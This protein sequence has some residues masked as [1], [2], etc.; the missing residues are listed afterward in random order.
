MFM[1]SL[2]IAG[3]MSASIAAPAAAAPPP[4]VSWTVGPVIAGRSYSH[5]VPP[6]AIAGPGRSWWVPIPGRS[7]SLN[8]LTMT[9]RPLSGA[10]RIVLTYRIE[11]GPGVTVSARSVPGAPA[12]V[13]LYLQRRGDDWSARGPYEAY[14]WYASFA[15]QTITPNVTRTIVAPLT[16]NWTAVERSS[17]RTSPA[18]FRAALADPQV[19]G[20]VLGGGDGLGHGIVADGPARLVVTDFRIE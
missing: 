5:E 6:R 7:G 10:R 18:A 4:P 17:A 1:R 20:F 19:V 9:A 13:T 14:R 8:A 2:A 12:L 11:A 16:G 15:T 3:A